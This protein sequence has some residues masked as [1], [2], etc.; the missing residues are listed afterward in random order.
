[1]RLTEKPFPSS[2]LPNENPAETKI[3]SGEYALTIG[4]I[5]FFRMNLNSTRHESIL[6]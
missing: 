2:F 4:S 1:M 5:L 6:I 3:R